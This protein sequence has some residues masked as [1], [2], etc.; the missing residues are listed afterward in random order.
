MPEASTKPLLLL[1]DGHSLAFRSFYAFSKG[2]EGGLATNDGRPTSVTYG[3]L[4]SLLD[5]GKS[6][7]PEGVAIAFDTAEPTFRHKAD[8]NYKAH[9]DVAPEV[10]FQDLDQLQEIL[11]HK[12]DL[13]LCMAPGY[14]A[15]DV[16]GTLANRA[17]DDGWGVRILS[18][19]R[20]LFQLVDDNRDIAVLYM[21]GGPYAKN[22]GPTL[23]REEGVLG[24][25]GV[26]PNKVVDLKALTG[27]SSDNIPGVRGVGPKTA[28]SLLK[29]NNDLD[30]VYATLEE[31]E[32]E[33]PKASRGAIKGALKGKLRNDK[34]NAYLSR[35]LAEILVD[36]PLPQ[37]PSLPLSTVNAEGLSSCL[38]DLEL[39]SLLRQVGGFVAA[40]SEGGYGANADAAAPAQPSSRPKVTK[41]DRGLEETV[42]SVPALR[43][44]LIQDTAALQGL[45][46]RLMTCTDTGSPVALDTETT[47]LNP[48]KAELV[49]IGV[50]WGEELDALAYIPLGHN[51]SA[52]SQPVQLPLETVVTA[53]APWLGSEDHPKALQ[54]AKFDR[55]ILMRHGLAL[56]GVVI[57]TLLADYLRDAAAKHGLE[58]MAE[59]EF[60]FQPTAYSD[61]VGKKQTF[62]DV[63]LEAASQYCA[64]DVHVTRRLALLLRNQLAA[65]GAQVLTLLEQ[66]EQPLEPVLAEMEATGIRIDV[67]YLQELS[68][69]MGTTLERLETEA[70]EAAGVDF[71]LA[72][73]KQLGELL[74]DTLGLDRKKSRRTKTGYS[75]DATVL[76]KLGDD[77]PVVPLVLEHRVLS[78]LKSTYIDALPQLVEAETGR[79]HTDF[80]QA[81]TATGRLSSSNPNLQN[82]PVR[83]E[84]SRRI[85]KAFLP[86]AGWTLLSADY[87]QI[88]LRI[89]THLSGEEVLQEAYRSGDDVH[90]LTARLL[91]DKDEVSADER[92]LGKTINFGVI[93]GMGAQR[94]ARETGVSQSEAKDFLSKYKQ[95]YPKVFA[96]L[97]LQE[98]LALS[99]GYVETILG[100]R[101]PF[102]FDRNGLGRLLGK[103]PLEIDL[104]VARRGGMEAQQ[105][106]AAANAPIQGSS[107]DIIK[108]AMVQLQAALTSQGLPARL[109]LQVHDEL[110]LEVEPDA[111]ETTRD[112][113]VR[114]MENAVKL[115]VPLV[116]ETG[117][118]ANWMEAK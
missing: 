98:R 8:A 84:Y 42:G 76:E 65:M 68:T 89:L 103:E 115:T 82:I 29:D 116:A 92:R 28:I 54:N 91:L 53:L 39:N 14:E 22:S 6:L 27:D 23:I 11:R 70:K 87:S 93:Y 85:R 25:L 34:D 52:D 38:E 69:E 95:R 86:Q 66:V 105:L 56:D 109:L 62:A 37:E 7:K 32:A 46:Q 102:H 41:D 81:V 112:M 24:K 3:F 63:P 94:F 75:T 36:I 26:M 4:K 73:P 88:E 9:R 108:V 5:T 57:D 15:D 21:G 18:G 74:F 13:P 58:L 19:D 111:L 100:R 16:L 97:E 2:G 47:D 79:V 64:M 113:V 12:L 49:G 96:F 50:C 83:T 101:R 99:R 72:S 30:A 31:L 90:A 40:F 114:T 59:R 45:V 106:R 17:A 67:P 51:G 44:Q 33:G 80:N 60:G 110:V 71:N 118:G 10:F 20:D 117:V 104:D 55:L 35:K 48:F 77:H 78:K 61:L 1:V 43:P 107:A